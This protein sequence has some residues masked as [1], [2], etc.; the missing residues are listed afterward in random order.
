M[1]IRDNQREQ[2]VSQEAASRKSGNFKPVNRRSPLRSV[3]GILTSGLDYEIVDSEENKTPAVVGIGDVRKALKDG[4]HSMQTLSSDS[5]QRITS[6]RH[7]SSGSGR[8][9]RQDYAAAESG[10]WQQET[11]LQAIR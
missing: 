4:L 9:E 5:G 1:R 8:T 2:L 7:S 6:F 11:P 3:Q 10:E